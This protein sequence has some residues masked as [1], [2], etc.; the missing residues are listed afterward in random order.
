MK[1]RCEDL[2]ELVASLEKEGV[3]GEEI[4]RQADD[5]GFDAS[6]FGGH[7]SLAKWTYGAVS[8]LAG[9]GACSVL[10]SLFKEVGFNAE[11]P[12][13]LVAGMTGAAITAWIYVGGYVQ[14]VLHHQ[15][16]KFYD[17]LREKYA[18]KLP[19]EKS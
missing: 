19:K 11:V 7:Y 18:D 2:S 4:E 12:R 8:I 1:S 9:F 5:N 16:N 15:N 14:G 17:F 6:R 10:D 3:K 13:A